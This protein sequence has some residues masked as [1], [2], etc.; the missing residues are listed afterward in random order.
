[1]YIDPLFMQFSDGIEEDKYVI[2]T[3]YVANAKSMEAVKYAAALAVEQ[4]TGTWISVPGET[5]E[6]RE[7]HLGRVVGI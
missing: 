5:H 4:T 1:M 7:K 3:Y 2:A 6:V